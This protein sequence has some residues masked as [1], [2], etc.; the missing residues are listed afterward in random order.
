MQESRLNKSMKNTVIGVMGTLLN[1]LFQFIARS[2]FIKILGEAYNGVNGLFSSILTILNLA[3]LG[4]GS[5]IAFS[6]Y[7]PLYNN[8]Q[9]LVTAYMNYFAKVYRIIAL[10]VTIAGIICIPFLP[11]LINED[12]T[13]LP[14]KL[15][16]LRIYFIFYLANTVSSYLLA[17]KR[18]VITADQ[19]SYIV[20]ISDNMSNVIMSIVQIVLLLVFKNFYVF[21]TAMLARTILNNIVLTFIANKRYPYLS[22]FKK[23]ELSKEQKKNLFSNINALML[24]KIG[25]VAIFGTI[26]LVISARVGVVSAG[27]YSNYAT[28][29]SG[30]TLLGTI[31]FDSILASVG[32]LCVEA[33]DD[34]KYRIFKR[35]DFMG[36]W[37]AIFCMV[38][39]VNL[40]NT[41]INNIWIRSD[42]AH[43]FEFAVVVA[44]SLSSYVNF[45]RKSVLMF[46]DAMGLFKRDWYKPLIEAGLGIALAIGLSYVWGIFGIIL[47]YTLA[48]IFIAIPIESY[49]LFKYGLNKGNGMFYTFK[50]FIRAIFALLLSIG[51]YYLCNLFNV[52]G[53]SDFIVRLIV[54]FIV[55][56][57]V[58]FLLSIRDD[59]LKYYF[60]LVKRIFVKRTK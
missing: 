57:S 33:T 56:I 12:L 14:F 13:E 28:I 58:T 59:N 17:Y 18:T 4:F 38:C 24:H 44:I 30:V 20:S 15:N 50:Q 35:I 26:S 48:S 21:L 39:Y 10:I 51:T 40:F 2:I 46:R 45:S 27:I 53:F 49:V 47:G 43:T 9:K 31:V 37:F 36:K 11:Y 52:E 19:R 8:D 7:K 22:E 34:E 3:E 6:L 60:R 5:A 32:N 41:F 16:Q 25:G 23:V 55:S 1:L 54:S 29:I 42:G